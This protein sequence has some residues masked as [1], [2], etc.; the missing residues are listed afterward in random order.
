MKKVY[1]LV[2]ATSFASMTFAQEKALVKNAQRMEAHQ[3][4]G[5]GEKTIDKAPIHAFTKAPGDPIFT[6]NFSTGI[7]AWTTAGT[8]GALWAADTDGPNGQYSNPGNERIQSTSVANGFAIFDADLANAAQPFT[9]WVGSLVSPVINMTGISN[10]I[11][12]FQHRYRTCCSGD[13]YPRVEVSTDGFVTSQEFNV[14]IPG[15]AV[16]ATSPTQTMKVNVSNFLATAGNPANFQFRFTWD[17]G[18]GTSHYHWQI[19]DVLLYEANNNDLTGLNK[20]LVSGVNEIPYHFIPV[21]QRAPIVFSGEVRNDGGT[22]QNGVQLTVSAN[23][24]GGSVS[25]PTQT[26]AAGV[27]D[28][29]VTTGWT[30]PATS[31]TNYTLTYTFSQTETDATPTD[32]VLTE[33]VSVTRSTYSVDNGVGVSFISNLSTQQGQGLKIGNVMEVMAND[34]IDS[35]YITTATATTNVGQEIYGEVWR[36]NGTE[37]EYLGTTPYT[38]IT[39]ATN[40]TTMKLPLESV[41][42][43]S[44]GDLLLVL[45]CHT[46]GVS[47]DVRFRTAQAVEEGIVQGFTAAGEAFFLASPSAVMVR[48]NIQPT[49]A[50]EE[51]TASVSLGNIFPNPTS[52]TTSINYTLANATD[53]MITV[54]DLTG[55]VMLTSA[56]GTQNAGSHSLTFDAASFAAGVYYVTIATGET[57]VTKKFIKK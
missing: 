19:D 12:T 3:E 55:K 37:W 7:G 10:A 49:A 34:K 53:V 11:L 48:L 20:V 22:T 6:E 17:G 24:G 18:G 50:I 26:L 46:G 56:E 41:I 39:A 15:V 54:A 14:A 2:A 51:N 45:A 32:N 8:D 29:L 27:T 31:P 30:P 47:G 36:D 1:L 40:G 4:L 9:N 35:M 44:A 25:S 23:N 13:F 28:S 33:T 43:V 16:N 5:E 57:T 38:A 52:G 21:N 42:D